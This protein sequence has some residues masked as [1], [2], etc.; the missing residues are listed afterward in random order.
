M[1]VVRQLRW[2]AYVEALS[3][4]ATVDV[5]AKRREIEDAKFEAGEPSKSARATYNRT[6]LAEA[7]IALGEL[8]KARTEVREQLWPADP[9]EASAAASS[10]PGATSA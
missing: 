2:V 4:F 9:P 8:V 1:P 6:R 10:A 7:Q 3:P 5:D